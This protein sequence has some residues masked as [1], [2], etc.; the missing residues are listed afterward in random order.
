MFP[1]SFA[2]RIGLDYRHGG[3]YE[4]GGAG[5]PNQPA[6]FF[7]LTL[8]IGTVLTYQTR[9]GFTPAL[10]AFGVGLLGQQGF[11]DRFKVEFDLRAGV[12]YIEE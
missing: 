9:V 5:A 10:E 6:G 1:A 12:F 7:N 4:F 2:E 8:T 3:Y 11:F